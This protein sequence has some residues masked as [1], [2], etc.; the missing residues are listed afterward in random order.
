V[1]KQ[2]RGR[3]TRERI[4][5]AAVACFERDG[6]DA[7]TTSRIA[8]RAGVGVGTLY[9]YFPDKRAVLLELLQDTVRDVASYVVEGLEPERWRDAPLRESVR[10]L[11][12]AV[13]HARTFQ[14]GMQRIIWERYFKDPEFQGAVEAIEG[15]VRGAIE[16]LLRALEEA[17]KIR[18]TDVRTA[19]FLVYTSVEWTAARLVLGG[20]RG[21]EIDAA[22]EAA[23]D[24]V[25]RYLFIGA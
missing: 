25:T 1:P 3:R 14:P 17:G 5:R 2:V 19:A 15:R 9:G 21:S 10:G 22:V 13:F 6:Y 16:R 8:R 4:L 23:T 7:T 18:V 12:D 20:A 11:I 24:M